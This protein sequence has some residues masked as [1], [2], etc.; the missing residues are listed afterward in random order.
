MAGPESF[1]VGAGGDSLGGWLTGSGTPLLLLHGGPGLSFSYLD[2]LTAELDG[3]FRVASFQQRGLAPSTLEGPFTVDQAIADAVSVLDGLGWDRALVVGHSWGGHLALRVAA[4]HPER[5]LGALAL[6]PIGV[7]G[8]GGMAAF[9]A[10]VVAR[11]PV[12]VRK[13]AQALDERAMAGEGTPGESY[14]SM[15]LVWPSYFADP[16]NV[17]E[18]PA[19]EISI[20]A[21]SGIIG[22]ITAGTDRVSAELAKGAVPYGIVAGAASPIPWGQAAL[23]SV[24]LSPR[25]FLDVVPSAGHFVWFEA[26]GRVRAALKRLTDDIANT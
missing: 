24:E 3:E 1:I 6:D 23:A 17:P 20:E 12:A 15:R 8:D 19:I 10:E 5:L 14:E 22:E 25:A 11:T 9:E 13:R 26:P 2:D 21:Y 4:G 16:E 18:M 7:V